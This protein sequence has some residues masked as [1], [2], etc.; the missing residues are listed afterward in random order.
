M[1]FA[2]LFQAMFALYREIT[3]PYLILSQVPPNTT[4]HFWAAIGGLPL[5]GYFSTA[6]S[7]G[8]GSLAVS[9]A[10]GRWVVCFLASLSLCVSLS[11]APIGNHLVTQIMAQR[12][13]TED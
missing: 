8:L 11:A 13:L 6:L 9:V 2:A 5:L 7:V 3:L 10:R 1:A 4:G 12:N